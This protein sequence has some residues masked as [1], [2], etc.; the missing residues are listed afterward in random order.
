MSKFDIPYCSISLELYLKLSTLF[1]FDYSLS[2]TS[3]FNFDLPQFRPYFVEYTTGYATSY[4]LFIHAHF[5][6][7]ALLELGYPILNNDW[8][9][10]RCI[11][12]MHQEEPFV[13]Q[14]SPSFCKSL[15]TK[16]L[17]YKKLTDEMIDERLNKFVIPEGVLR[18]KQLHSSLDIPKNVVVKFE[19]CIYYDINK[20]YM[21]ALIEIFPELRGWLT[22]VA[23][24]SKADKRY[25][26]IANYYVGLLGSKYSNHRKTYEWI[27][28]RTTKKMHKLLDAISNPNGDIVYENTDGFVYH[29]PKIALETSDEIGDIK[30]ETEETTFYMFNYQDDN[31]YKTPYKMLQYG[32][33]KKC[34]SNIQ[35]KDFEYIDLRKGEVISYK[36]VANREKH[37]KNHIEIERFKVGIIEYE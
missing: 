18:E 29:N 34:I 8:K 22:N 30:L 4:Y 36:E 6:N 11:V 13:K 17:H 20:A 24:K 12:D 37:T 33:E 14:F 10:Y 31:R 3:D 21:D 7:T 16:Q 15:V 28:D 35:I 2:T 25:K 32:N 23:K 9:R 27:V 5:I 1:E 26:N 19:N